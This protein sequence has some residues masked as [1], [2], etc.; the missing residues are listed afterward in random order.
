LCIHSSHSEIAGTWPKTYLSLH[1]QPVKKSRRTAQCRQTSS[2]LVSEICAAVTLLP[3]I[4][5]G[6]SG[7]NEG[8]LTGVESCVLG[9]LDGEC[10]ESELPIADVGFDAGIELGVDDADGVGIELGVDTVAI[11][12]ERKS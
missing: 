3:W 1:Q 6:G 5:F 11:L 9:R 2:R 8:N 4:R 7:R 12:A 10:E